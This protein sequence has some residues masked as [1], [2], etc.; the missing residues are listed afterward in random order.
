MF[1]PDDA[2]VREYEGAVSAAAWKFSK[3]A[4]YDDLYQEGM[5]AVWL[6]PPDADPPYIQ[7]SIY[8]RMKDWLRFVKRLRH[9]QTASYDEI[10]EHVI[11]DEEDLD[12][13]LKILQELEELYE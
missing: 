4:E 1:D 6:C 5:I 9:F 13:F 3:A 12:E 7:K 8:N 11:E 10:M 2:R